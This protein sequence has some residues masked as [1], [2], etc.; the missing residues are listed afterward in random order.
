[1]PTTEQVLT[2]AE[3]AEHLPRVKGR[4]VHPSALWRWA[5]YGVRGVRLE[6]MLIGGRFFTTEEAIARF[7]REIAKTV[8]EDK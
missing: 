5:R 8:R 3:A 4:A 1:M 7:Q 6:A 2:L